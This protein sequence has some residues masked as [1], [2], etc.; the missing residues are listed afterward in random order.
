MRKEPQKFDNI[1]ASHSLQCNMTFKN[2]ERRNGT[3]RDLFLLER[4]RSYQ[5]LIFYLCLT[6]IHVS[7]SMH[8]STIP[9][10]SSSASVSSHQPPELLDLT[11]T[12]CRMICEPLWP[13]P[14]H[15]PSFYPCSTHLSQLQSKVHT[16]TCHQNPFSRCL[17]SHLCSP[18]VARSTRIQPTPLPCRSPDHA[19]YDVAVDVLEVVVVANGFC[20]GV[21][22]GGYLGH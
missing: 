20:V 10:T 11:C 22:C 16:A 17:Y 5:Q 6:F 4:T 2:K 14:P 8:S 3:K 7:L 15:G 1:K 19:K 18:L 21:V 12:S 9:Q 13:H